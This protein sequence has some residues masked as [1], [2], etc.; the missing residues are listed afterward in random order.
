[1]RITKTD[2]NNIRI[3]ADEALNVIVNDEIELKLE[4]SGFGK[5]QLNFVYRN[6]HDWS[7]KRFTFD[8]RFYANYAK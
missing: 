7:Q 4:S 6:Y 8:I 1:M 3:K 5:G 2:K